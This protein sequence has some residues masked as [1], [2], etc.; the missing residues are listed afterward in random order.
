MNSSFDVKD[1][2]VA[3]GN[4]KHLVGIFPGQALSPDTSLG[5]IL[6]NVGAIGIGQV[7]HHHGQE[8]V[9]SDGFFRLLGELA[10][11][12]ALFEFAEGTVL[13]QAT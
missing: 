13:D 12:P 10:Q 9:A 8:D 1:G 7:E 4:D 5:P 6:T 3:P 11:Q 2:I